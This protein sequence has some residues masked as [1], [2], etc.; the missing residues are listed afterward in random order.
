MTVPDLCEFPWENC[1]TE[2]TH[3]FRIDRPELGAGYQV[4]LC[5]VHLFEELST[6]P[7]PDGHR[8]QFTVTPIEGMK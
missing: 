1:W 3:R 4:D 6:I 5:D 2:A 8:R 7:S